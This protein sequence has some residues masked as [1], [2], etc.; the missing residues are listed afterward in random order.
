VTGIPALLAALG[1]VAV[2]FGLLSALLALF[3]PVTDLSWI[4]GNLSVGVL[5]LATAL[6]VGFD[7][8]RQRLHSGEARRVGKYGTSA[9][10]STILTV[11]ILA[12]LAFL[13]ER[14][15]IRW[16]WSEGQV[17]TLTDQSMELVE[18][19][20]SDVVVTAYF[21]RS[22]IPD[23]AALLDRYGHASDRV[24]VEFVDPNSI[25]LEIESLGLDPEALAKGLVR[26]SSG[27]A[28][29]VVTELS[30]S[31]IT[32]GLLKLT[33]SSDKKV[34]FIEGHNER[35]ITGDQGGVA[36]GKE[37]MGRAAEALRNETYQVEALSMTTRGEIPE[38]ADAVVIAGP[39]RPY[40]DHEIEALRAYARR[41]G[42]LLFMIDP[43]AQTNLYGLLGEWGIR[44]EDD[45]VVDQVQAIYNQATMPL[46]AEYSPDHPITRDLDQ[47]TLYAVVRSVEFDD[48]D[49]ETLVFT[50]SSS[51]A[52]RDLDGWQASGRAEYD[53]RDLDGPVPIA[54]A[55]TPPV[56]VDEGAPP[57][58]LVV[59]GDSDF[60]SNEFL[61]ARYN[62]DLFL[63]TVNW[64]VGD[65][66]QISIRPQLSRASRFELGASQFRAILYLSL[67]V[68]PEGIAVAGVVAWWLRRGRGGA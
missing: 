24:E 16:D 5:L 34:Y 52:E 60:A 28:G 61:E 66:E 42:A 57:P 64:L 31:G 68:L 65:V 43:R 35:R 1:G 46:A 39:T 3:Q 25:P 56:E 55:G 10:V 18:R 59:F 22:E 62:R 14:H 12:M 37:S 54:V 17:N 38:D 11:A 13:A 44:L 30:E 51:W 29:I 9:I 32:N 8:I 58:R 19:L 53:E 45:V 2:A 23:V 21:D 47:T 27:D 36:E 20:D 4:I 33:R 6:F 7:A 67:F 48:G 63:N 40:F 41:G 50:G 15:S 26:V 49:Y